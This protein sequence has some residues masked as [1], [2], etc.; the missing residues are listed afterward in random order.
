MVVW[1]MSMVGDHFLIFWKESAMYIVLDLDLRV[2]HPTASQEKFRQYLS[3]E[4]WT[5][6]P[7][8]PR[9]YKVLKKNRLPVTAMIRARTEVSM[10][11]SA[12]GVVSYQATVHTNDIARMS[13]KEG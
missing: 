3:E 5:P 6:S 7:R 13:W 9:W 1:S 10:L 12:A 4:G 2:V 8:I 11:A